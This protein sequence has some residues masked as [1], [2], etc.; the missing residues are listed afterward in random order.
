MHLLMY[1]GNTIYI[2]GVE[3]LRF[4]CSSRS[5]LREF[6]PWSSVFWVSK[7]FFEVLDSC[8]NFGCGSRAG[9]PRGICLWF[10]KKRGCF[11]FLQPVKSRSGGIVLDV[12]PGTAL[13]LHDQW[14]VRPRR[15]P[16]PDQVPHV[17]ISE[18]PLRG[19][20]WASGIS[21]PQDAGKCG[22]GIA[23]RKAW[24][25]CKC[26]GKCLLKAK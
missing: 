13:R 25:W 6:Y 7:R 2:S 21:C 24:A 3:S 19:E 12:K 1:S 18:T 4:K 8:I 10:R 23:S 20:K 15:M 22:V 9:T 5:N 14:R 16:T 17:E 11:C 26:G